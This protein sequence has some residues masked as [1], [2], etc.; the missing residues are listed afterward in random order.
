M[1]ISK[2]KNPAIGGLAC[3][4]VEAACP[5]NLGEIREGHRGCWDASQHY[6][7]KVEVLEFPQQRE[8]HRS[9][10]FRSTDDIAVV[11]CPRCQERSSAWRAGIDC[12]RGD[13]SQPVRIVD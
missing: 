11:G 1:L 3:C 6:V 8:Q 12:E 7:T 13:S 5:S 4:D 2:F 9:P 10:V